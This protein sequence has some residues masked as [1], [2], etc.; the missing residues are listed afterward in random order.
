[1]SY[2]K[3]ATTLAN[4]IVIAFSLFFAMNVFSSINKEENIFKKIQTELNV[5]HLEHMDL[6]YEEEC[7]TTMIINASFAVLLAALWNVKK[8]IKIGTI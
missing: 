2:N 1:M 5:K 4:V 6:P 3:Y 7:S 8:I